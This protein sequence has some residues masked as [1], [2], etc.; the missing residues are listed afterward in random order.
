MANKWTQKNNLPSGVANRSI[1]K[2]FT[3]GSFGY[4]ENGLHNSGSG[5]SL[6]NDL[7]KYNPNT[8]SWVKVGVMPGTAR[9][10]EAV[11]VINGIPY[12][13][14]GND[15]AGNQYSDFWQMDTSTFIW[16]SVAGLTTG[17]NGSPY[18][19]IDNYGYIGTGSTQSTS[20]TN[21]NCL[22][23]FWQYGPKI[24]A[25]FKASSTSICPADSVQFSDRSTSR[26][27]TWKWIFTGGQP[28]T[29]TIKNPKVGYT[30][31]GT[32]NVK[33]VI[34]D[35]VASDSV[36]YNN[37]IT[38]LSPPFPVVTNN[39]SGDFCAGVGSLQSNFVNK[40]QWYLNGSI[41]N[42]D[43][44]QV[45]FPNQ[46]GFYSVKVV[47]IHGCTATSSLT[48][49]T[50]LPSP[51]AQTTATKD[52]ICAG[53]ST[54]LNAFGNGTYSWSTTE[55]LS[56]IV[57]TP[58]FSNTYFLTVTGGNGCTA[59]ATQNVVVNPLP[60]T[61]SIQ[62]NSNLLASS[63]S[64]GNQWNF[65]GNPISGATGQ[66]YTPIQSGFYSVTVTGINGCSA[67]S[68]LINYTVTGVNNVDIQSTQVTIY[69]NPSNGS[70]SVDFISITNENLTIN[71]YNALGEVVY[72]KLITSGSKLFS[73]DLSE[74]I[75]NGIYT[76]ML[77]G[78]T[79]NWV[80]KFVL[81]K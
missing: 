52:T 11:F 40:N 65:N 12:S 14:T 38:V 48:S 57:V 68:N 3:L 5:Y 53:S 56:S 36:T 70:F 46:S 54:T 55:S 18:F 71:I 64:T 25:S 37:Y 76:L 23:D 72:S 50:V 69:P 29:S 28:S 79:G 7:W 49:L 32:Y 44:T 41:I 22:K 60:T 51:T 13:G 16:S 21:P 43:T 78:N 39:A 8:D 27:A 17:R 63:A 80:Q 2:S 20:L 1:P 81:S 61:P 35:S 15:L 34:T 10:N 59:T 31:T 74:S 58:S 75:S 77:Q 73:I 67:N 6:S 26:V 66:F 9:D 45:I 4:V 24:G 62:Q 30:N 33:L 47:D 19:V 42:A